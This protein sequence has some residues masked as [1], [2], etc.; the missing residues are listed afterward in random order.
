MQKNSLK[1]HSINGRRRI[2]I[3][4]DELVNREI[5]GAILRDTYDTVFASDGAEALELVRENRDNLSLVLLDILMPKMT[6]LEVLKAVKADSETAQIP[7]IVVTSEQKSEI[8][9]LQLGAI[10]FIPKPYPDA[11]VIHARIQRTI[12][13]SEDRNIIRSTERDTLT[14][15]Y[16]REYFYR[17]AEQYDQYNKDAETDAILVDINHFHLI[18][19]RYGKAFGDEILQRVAEAARSI[20]QE[21][22][23]IVCR[24]EADAFMIYC[25]HREDHRSMLERISEATAD[26]DTG[27]NRVR[28]RMGVY[29]CADK[30]LDVER[31]FDRAKMASDSV[32]GSLTN[33]VGFYDNSLHKR[34]IYAEQLVE[35]FPSAIEKKQFKVYYQP[36]FDIRPDT[37]LLVGAEALVRWVHPELG[38]ISPGVFIPLFEENGL[39]QRLDSFVWEETARQMR[40]WKD[41]FGYAVPVSVNVSRIDLLDAGISRTLQEAVKK[42]GLSNDE[43]H[44]EVT[45]SA[46]TQDSSQIIAVVEQLRD[47]GFQIEM[48]DFGTGYS[49][50]NMISSLPIDSLKLD[51]QFVRNA[52]KEG[53]NTH[54]IEIIIDIADYLTVPVI[55]EGVETEEQLDVLRAMGCDIVQGYFF[56][57]PVP[58]SEFEAFILQKK[59]TEKVQTERVRAGSGTGEKRKREQE[60]ET[61]TLPD[62]DG[63]QAGPCAQE[64]ADAPPHSGIHLRTANI[65]FVILAFVAAA[66]LFIADISVAQGY[67]RM[68]LASDRY[69]EAQLSASDMESGSDYLTDRVRCFVVTGDK[70]YLNDFFKEV[71]VTRRRDA[72]VENLGGLLEGSGGAAL[73]SLNDALELSNELLGTEYVAMRLRLEADG[74]S[75]AEIPQELAAIELSPQDR[76]LSA[77]EKLK[78]AQTLVF[79]NNYMHYKD[80]IRENVGLCTQALIRTSSQE[81]ETA[82]SR[83][84]LLVHIQTALTVFFLFIVLSIVVIIRSQIQKPLSRMVKMMQNS[85]TLPPTGAEELRFVTRTYNKILEENREARERL[86]HEASHDALTGLFNRGAYDMLMESVDREHMALILID[87]DYFKAVND[88]YGHTIGDRVLQKVAD[89]LQKS[90]RSVDIICRIGGDEFV[91]IMTRSNSTM[92]QLV[93]NKIN[94]ANDLL[95]HPKDGLPPVSLSVGV[96]FSDRKNPKGDI[97]ADA[98]EALYRVKEAGRNGCAFFE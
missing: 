50:L 86:S 32:R 38:L 25:P 28:L 97:F 96:A 93:L 14:G 12:E 46:Y 88:N 52:F 37:P 84:S 51:M 39:I 20:A 18:N 92:R 80:R 43:L 54:L 3:A 65:F 53:G 31:R 16:N 23:G 62:G 89:I 11:G 77:D 29:P 70:E 68:K 82:S 42:Y 44:L 71:H 94:R 66:A 98:D 64:A 95:R 83:M 24:R 58:A 41:R 35:D 60:S 19:E 72:A 33:T 15:L 49:S 5:L 10:D 4:D 13:L 57:K 81:L 21:C 40:Q 87:V 63:E 30:T 85:E 2:L 67:E 74:D 34:E 61:K 75:A 69:I 9:S 1:F 79:D 36:K 45:E 8:E 56:S 27:N 90:F 55:A 76:S 59:E 47:L 91:V 17:Y 48:D 22:G 78:K 7:I 6:G 26:S 73:E